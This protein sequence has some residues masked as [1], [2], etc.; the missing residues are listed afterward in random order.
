MRWLEKCLASIPA[1]Y[2]VI[3]V[4]NAS[5]DDTV[6]FITDHYPQHRLFAQSQ[7][8]GFG[9]AN[10][11]GL[12]HALQEGAESCFLL[13]QDA[14]L[15]TDTIEKLQIC[16]EN[17]PEFSLLSPIHFDGTDRK[18]DRLFSYYLQYDHNPDFYSDAIN[19]ELK[20]VYEIA[21]VNAAGWF[22]PKKT[23]QT[24]GGFDP[25]F[26]HYGE[27][28][29]YCHRLKYHGLK[30]GVVPSAAMIHD[31][32]KRKMED[33]KRYS[34]KDVDKRM[35]KIKHYVANPNVPNNE[36]ILRKKIKEFKRKSVKNILKGNFDAYTYYRSLT[37]NLSNELDQIVQHVELN[38][39][40]GPH[41]L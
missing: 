38:K 41:Y 5:T 37:K 23:L 24:I 4:D 32:A 13:N 2:P 33:I 35:L 20:Q 40:T 26:F 8:L 12:T 1:Q 9:K 14:Y 19:Q 28:E 25:V 27:D 11:L 3:I 36:V 18:L 21:F 39:T 6:Q 16:Y 22:L 31:R 15:R 30:I 10:N 7:N 29:N 34:I 17:H